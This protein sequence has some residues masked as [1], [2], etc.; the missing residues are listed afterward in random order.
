VAE[1]LD[2]PT[3]RPPIALVGA[4]NGAASCH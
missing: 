1:A 2:T 3:S 4:G